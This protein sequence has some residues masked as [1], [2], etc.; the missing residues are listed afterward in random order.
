M[1]FHVFT[2]FLSQWYTSYAK[3]SVPFFAVYLYAALVCVLEP[4]WICSGPVSFFCQFLV[5]VLYMCTV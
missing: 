2:V 5:A 1:Y 4:E 3:I